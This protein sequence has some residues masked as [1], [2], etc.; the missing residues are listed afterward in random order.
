MGWGS[1]CLDAWPGLHG[2]RLFV[3]LYQ[4][5]VNGIGVVTSQASVRSRSLRNLSVIVVFRYLAGQAPT[6]PILGHRCNLP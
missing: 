3:L 5:Q 2:W 4:Y 1:Y 6:D